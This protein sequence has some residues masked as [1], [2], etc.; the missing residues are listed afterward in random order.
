MK[1]NFVVNNYLLVWNLLYSPS[2]SIK[3]NAF[4][5]KLWLTYKS[6]YQKI[7]KDNIEILK[8]GKNFIPSDNTMYDYLDDTKLYD[9]LVKDAEK[10]RISILKMWDQH[11]KN[12][13]YELKEILKTDIEDYSVFVLPSYMDS[14]IK[15]KECK[16]IGWGKKQD[17][18]DEVNTLTSIIYELLLPTI[19]I[20]K[21]EIDIKIA[22]SVLEF[23]IKNELYTRINKN[24]NMLAG[25]KELKEFKEALYPYLLMYLGID[26]ENTTTY[27]MRDNFAFDISKYTDEVKL[28]KLNY[29][30]FIDFLVR[31]KRYVLK[32]KKIGLE[33]I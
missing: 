7:E 32:I 31:N 18:N 28:R 16:N 25:K 17:L 22:K 23:L 2:I 11:K 8:D 12:I 29:L 30:E 5:K 26:L 33:I 21:D 15:V 20:Y 24:S 4:K 14:V 13:N 3:T 19:D 6:A 10:H 1:L 9:R 27:M